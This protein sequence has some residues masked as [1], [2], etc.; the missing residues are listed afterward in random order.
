PAFVS[1]GHLADGSTSPA[2]RG[3]RAS[4]DRFDA[5]WPRRSRETL[6][7]RAKQG[8]QPSS[9]VSRD[10]RFVMRSQRRPKAGVHPELHDRGRL[11]LTL[12]DA[13]APRADDGAAT[14]L[15]LV[16]KQAPR[17]GQIKLPQSQAEEWS[18]QARRT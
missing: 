15:L 8:A 4:E 9:L 6:E 13:G 2:P 14:P 7:F 12:R 11:P 18:R 10:S 16:P 3:K 1:Y 5:S 17:R